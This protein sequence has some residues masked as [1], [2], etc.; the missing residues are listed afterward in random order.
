MKRV[1][2]HLIKAQKERIILLASL[3]RNFFFN[4][5]NLKNYISFSNQIMCDTQKNSGK[6]LFT[7]PAEKKIVEENI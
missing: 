6:K 2:V 1:L 3:T 7:F 4:L 5:G